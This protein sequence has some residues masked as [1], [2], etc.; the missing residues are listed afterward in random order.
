MT[1]PIVVHVEGF[2]DRNFLAGMLERLGWTPA[3]DRPTQE[4]VKTLLGDA[5]TPNTSFGY[6]SPRRDRA[7]L[8]NPGLAGA[9]ND[10]RVFERVVHSLSEPA[11]E[12]QLVACVDSDAA[13]DDVDPTRAR[14]DRVRQLDPGG[15]VELC[16]W[17]WKSGTDRPGVPKTHT[18]ERLVLG[19]SSEL[20]GSKDH[21]AIV[22]RFLAEAPQAAKVT[23][24]HYAWATM[25]KWYGEGGCGDFYQ[26]LWREDAFARA[27]LNAMDEHGILTVLRA[28]L[29]R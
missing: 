29:S 2:D 15:R 18:L 12:R 25:A 16:V 10:E 6:L 1:A 13:W 5:R 11:R 8:V 20:D 22:A 27:M 26:A 23:G 21:G 9:G 24:K 4:R 19:V 17:H 3:R 7:L 28:A 14:Q